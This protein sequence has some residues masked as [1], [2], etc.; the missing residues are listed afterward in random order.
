[1]CD[2]F[3]T[4]VKLKNIKLEDL[5]GRDLALNNDDQQIIDEI[6]G[7]PEWE[8][9]VTNDFLLYFALALVI[10]VLFILFKLPEVDAWLSQFVSSYES[11][12]LLELTLVF[13]I[14]VLFDRI[15][16]GIRVRIQG[17]RQM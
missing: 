14:V 6:F 1:M 12:L 16:L 8:P 2:D 15:F 17:W 7:A 4:L 11:L 5:D 10:A 9:H 13:L 3:Y